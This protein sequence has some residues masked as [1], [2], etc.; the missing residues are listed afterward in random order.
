MEQFLFTEFLQKKKKKKNQRKKKA[1]VF[2]AQTLLLSA[3]INCILFVSIVYTKY[4][5][6]F[7]Y[8]S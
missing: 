3:S 1:I 8:F 2:Q 5:Q 4:K 6:Q 7:Y